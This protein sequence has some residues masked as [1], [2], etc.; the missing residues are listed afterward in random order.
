MAL[1]SE[2]RGKSNICYGTMYNVVRIQLITSKNRGITNEFGIILSQSSTH[3]VDWNGK[4]GLWPLEYFK[5]SYRPT[6]LL[7]D[8]LKNRPTKKG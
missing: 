5:I 2:K 3:W 4:A 7:I 6:K 1:K 8:N